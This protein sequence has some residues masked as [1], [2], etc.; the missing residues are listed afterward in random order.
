[1]DKKITTLLDDAFFYLLASIGCIALFAMIQL[2]MGGSEFIT[3]DGTVKVE[4]HTAVMI[5]LAAI[6]QTISFTIIPNIKQP[7]LKVLL[8]LGINVGALS[9]G[10]MSMTFIDSIG[11]FDFNIID[12]KLFSFWILFT[13]CLI[14]KV[15]FKKHINKIKG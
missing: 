15:L 14:A 9:V 6:S 4:I 13:I 3:P 11:L 12:M 7:L 2:I 10:F 1:M 5:L 8:F